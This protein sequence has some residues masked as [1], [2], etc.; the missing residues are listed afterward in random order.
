MIVWGTRDWLGEEEFLML[1]CEG[2]RANPRIYVQSPYC[3][4]NLQPQS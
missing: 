4:R 2:L 3:Y 1:K